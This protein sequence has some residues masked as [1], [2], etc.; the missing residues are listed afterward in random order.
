M[1]TRLTAAVAA[2]VLALS[3]TLAAPAPARAALQMTGAGSTYAALAIQQWMADAKRSGLD[4]TYNANGSPAGVTFFLDKTVDWAGTEAEVRSVENGQD[5]GNKSYQYVP[6]VAGAIAFM[7]N[8]HDQA[9]RKVNFLHL[10]RDVIA[11]IFTGEITSWNDSRIT[12]QN[13]GVHF[14]EDTINVVVRSERSG[15]TGL[16]YDFVQHTAPA[17]FARFLQK[18]KI[19]DNGGARVIELPTPYPPHWAGYDG[20]DKIAQTIAG[21]QGAGMIGYDEFGYAKAFGAESAFVQNAAGKWVQPYAQ[22]ISAALEKAN[23]RPDLTQELSG[24]Y[25]NP[26]PLAYPVSA[27]SYIM[28]PCAPA[29]DR[30]TCRSPFY[31][32]ARAHQMAQWLDYI[33]CAGQVKMASIG[34]SPLP[35]NL[36]QEVENSITRMGAGQRGRTLTPSNCANPRFHGSLG[37]GANSPPDPLASLDP[38]KFGPGGGHASAGPSGSATAGAATPG[39]GANGSS[40]TAAGGGSTNW[41]GAS[42]VAYSGSRW[43]PIGVAAAVALL[44]LVLGPPLAF[45]VLARI[46]RRR[47]D[48]GKVS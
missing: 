33:A 6:D 35:P 10:T 30:S 44:L 28:T 5:P 29:R 15:T 12:S 27:Y 32:T 40:T 1:Y 14:K 16:F 7:Y 21:P 20:S 45:A 2:L 43:A 24:V 37:A 38:S 34:Y 23:L 41:R 19:P 13:L 22:N 26:N 39:V 17:R 36:S 3:G 18:M 11:G 47:T 31:D 46:R 9:G 8:L 42:P 4:F 48:L 25:T